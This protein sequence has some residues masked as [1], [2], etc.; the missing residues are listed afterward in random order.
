MTTG[1]MPG[2][3]LRSAP[4]AQ[5]PCGR[6]DV[7]GEMERQRPL[8]ERAVAGDGRALAELYED[9]VDD[10]YRYLRAWTADDDAAKDLT[11]QVL[12]AMLTWL[13]AIAEGEGD[14]AAWLMT[15]ARDAVVQH[16]DAGWL[17][18]PEQV[19]GQAPDVLVAAAQLDDVRREVVVLRLLLGHS[20]AHTAHLTGYSAQVVS[21]LQLEACSAVWQMLSGAAVEPAPPGSQE[22]RPRWFEGCLEG[23]FYDPSTDPGLSDLVAVADALRQAAPQQVPLP[24]DVFLRRLREQLLGELGGDAS[25]RAGGTGRIGRGFAMVRWHV[26][27]HPWVATVVAASAIGLVFGLQ[28]ASGTGARSACGDQPCLASTT[29]STVVPQA[30]AAG[31]TIPTLG[32]TTILSSSSTAPPTTRPPTTRAAGGAPSTVPPTTVAQTQTSQQTTT[33]RRRG[34]PTTTDPPTTPTT[35]P[36][37]TPT[38]AATTPQ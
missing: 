1:Q 7:A 15:A 24:D 33:T 20:L 35:T 17:A 30:G 28:I 32:P 11:G 14:L 4:P 21:G 38:T 9:N 18:G 16:Q 22:L 8:L 12:H 25:E 13:P 6:G 2:V 19:G 34:K 31:P 10:V 26:G 29:E 27:R 5:C 37:T 36:P 23:A 3:G